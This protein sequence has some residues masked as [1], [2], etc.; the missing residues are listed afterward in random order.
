MAKNAWDAY[1]EGSIEKDRDPVLDDPIIYGVNE[2][3][4]MPD[5]GRRSVSSLSKEVK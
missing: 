1:F 5:S 3:I 4:F 2:L